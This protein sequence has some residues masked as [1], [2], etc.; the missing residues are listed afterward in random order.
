MSGSGTGTPAITPSVST[1]STM[2]TL[3]DE[4]LDRIPED[5]LLDLFHGTNM[6]IRTI[7]KRLYFHESDLVRGELSLPF[8]ADAE[9]GD[10]PADFWGLMSKP[11]I[12]GSRGTLIPLPDVETRLTNS[13]SGVPRF[14][15]VAGMRLLIFPSTASAIIVGGLYFQ[16]P[17]PVE[18]M[19][20]ALPYNGL[21]DDALQEY[22][23]AA[24]TTGNI[25]SDTMYTAM[26]RMMNDAVDLVVSKRPK[27]AAARM[28]V[29]TDWAALWGGI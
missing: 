29:G 22:I 4:F 12:V 1:P 5:K 27:K 25:L 8:L 26:K 11:W 9:Y 13:G 3:L 23:L 10:L 18:D 28:P 15:D 21:F 24:L 17:T 14:F 16:K 20:D 19:T 7:A 2:A 6:A